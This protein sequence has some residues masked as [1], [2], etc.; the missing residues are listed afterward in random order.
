[1][2]RDWRVSLTF[3]DRALWSLMSYSVLVAIDRK[4]K[5]C[6]I[7]PGF[8]DAAHRQAFMAGRAAFQARGG[9]RRCVSGAKHGGRCGGWALRGQDQCRFHAPVAVRRALRLRQLFRPRSMSQ[10]KRAAG[11]E[12]ARIQRIVWKRD[13]WALGGTVTLGERDAVF[14]DDMRALGFAVSRLSPASVDAARW[15]WLNVEA[16][17]MTIDQ[18]RDRVRWHAAQDVAG[19]R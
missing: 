15:A 6:G 18:F 2:R 16:G 5:S 19:G 8:H 10:A 1:M 13:R 12:R 17:R 14:F 3:N 11:R 4:S 7:I 9:Q